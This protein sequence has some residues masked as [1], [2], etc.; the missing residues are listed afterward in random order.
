MKEVRRSAPIG[1][2]LLVCLLLILSTDASVPFMGKL[3]IP[4]EAIIEQ[5]ADFENGEVAHFRLV[6]GPWLTGKPGVKI[7]P[8]YKIKVMLSLYGPISV[9]L[10]SEWTK[11]FQPGALDTLVFSVTA[12]TN[13][14][15]GF[16]LHFHLG[17]DSLVL[18][19]FIVTTWERPEVWPDE[20]ERMRIDPSRT[21]KRRAETGTW[22]SLVAKRAH[23]RRD[24]LNSINTGR[25]ELGFETELQKQRDLKRRLENAPLS[26]SLFE[27]IDLGNMR[28]IRF[29]REQYF[30]ALGA[31]RVSNGPPRERRLLAFLKLESQEDIKTAA[32][33]IGPFPNHK[34]ESS[35]PELVR[36][37]YRVRINSEIESQLASSGL[38]MVTYKEYLV[39]KYKCLHWQ[40][41]DSDSSGPGRP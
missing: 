16:R 14:T 18:R 28:Y 17:K 7:N 27:I 24:S 1:L 26:D 12:P 21:L 40:K 32:K 33:I 37:F 22:D 38:N 29:R 34:V 35:C 31:S 6:Y 20:P 25:I 9:D 19:K 11:S 39:E 15:T 41:L 2:V 4:I 36:G 10:P 13:D 23:A 3:G 30:S 8:P 5:V